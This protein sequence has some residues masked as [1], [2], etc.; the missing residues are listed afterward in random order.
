MDGLSI[1]ALRGAHDDAAGGA[2]GS[3]IPVAIH[4]LR[5]SGDPLRAYC[6]D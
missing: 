5:S 1:Y 4:D 3:P 2:A 6:D